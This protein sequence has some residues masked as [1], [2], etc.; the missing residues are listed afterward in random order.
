MP[1]VCH[2]IFF[3]SIILIVELLIGPELGKACRANP[4]L[5]ITL[6][7]RT[8]RYVYFFFVP[9]LSAI[10]SRF[11]RLSWVRCEE[12]F[13]THIATQIDGKCSFKASSKPVTQHVRDVQQWD[14]VF[15]GESAT[16]SLRR[17]SYSSTVCQWQL[18]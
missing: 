15:P 1:Y 7:F 5:Q 11:R 13:S 16:N 10:L 12:R 14:I 4:C 17:A 18:L 6:K 3:T 9:A 2:I 8:I